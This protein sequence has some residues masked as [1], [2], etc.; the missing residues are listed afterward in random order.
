[1]LRHMKFAP[2]AKVMIVALMPS[3]VKV[4]LICM[5]KHAALPKGSRVSYQS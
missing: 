5:H 1:M 4:V 2:K 3:T